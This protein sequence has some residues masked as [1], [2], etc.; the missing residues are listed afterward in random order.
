MKLAAYTQGRDNNLHLMRIL[1]AYAVLVSHSFVLATGDGAN[2]P[3]VRSLGLTLG[4]IAV[5]VFFLAS[6]LLVTASLLAKQDVRAFARARVLRIFPALL[7]MLAITVFV[8]GPALSQTPLRSYLTDSATYRHLLKSATL[9]TGMGIG[10]PGLFQDNPYPETV[11]GSLWTLKYELRMYAILAVAWFMMS[12][13]TALSERNFKWAVLLAAGV[14]GG[15]HLLSCVGHLPHR[16]STQLFFM[17]FTGASC[18]VL[19][20]RIGMSLGWFLT[21]AIGLLAAG[22]THTYF[23]LAYAL[24]LP[25]LLFF[26]AYVPSIGFIRAYNAVGDYSYGIYIYAFPVQ[27]AL[28]ACLPGMGILSLVLTSTAIVLPLAMMSWHLIEKRAIAWKGP[29]SKMTTTSSA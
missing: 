15:L 17:F 8:M 14:S 16:L 18:Y 6:G 1:A 27:Q 9:I 25:Y 26:L 28:L 19:R 4:S 20:H 29:R 23:L 10:L 11:N 5:D 7:V 2:E 13:F 3:F 12:R 24:T 22:I 21:L